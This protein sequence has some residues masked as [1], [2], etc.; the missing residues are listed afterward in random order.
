VELVVEEVAQGDEGA[1]I[2]RNRGTVGV[3]ERLKKELTEG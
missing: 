3:P 1:V 2:A